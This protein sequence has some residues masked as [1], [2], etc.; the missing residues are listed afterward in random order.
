[1]PAKTPP[2]AM[3]P[4]NSMEYWMSLKECRQTQSPGWRPAAWKPATSLRIVERACRLEMER[5]GLA[6]SM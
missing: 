1:M 5:E 3:M 6:A 2:A 4:R